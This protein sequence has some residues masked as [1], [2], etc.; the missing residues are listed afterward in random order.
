MAATPRYPSLYQINTRVWLNRLSREA[1]KRVTLADIDEA[2]FDGFA[3]QGFEWIWLLSVWQTGAAGRAVSRSNPQWR[4]EF[5]ALLPDL[6]EDEVRDALG[7]FDPL[8]EELF[9]VEQARIV[10]LLIERVDVSP[11]GADIRLRLAGLSSL[12]RELGGSSEK[13][14]A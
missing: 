8:W 5:K 10:R 4:A 1:G 9:P 3:Q 6:T 14:A 11:E 7:Q 2:A 13:D 12:I